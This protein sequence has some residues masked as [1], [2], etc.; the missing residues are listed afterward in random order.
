MITMQGLQRT[1]AF[2][3]LKEIHGNLGSV[4]LKEYFGGSS[5]RQVETKLRILFDPQVPTAPVRIA[6]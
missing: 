1:R 6:E 2:N 4:R 5:P 3:R